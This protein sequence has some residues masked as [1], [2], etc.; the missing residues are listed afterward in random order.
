MKD[1]MIYN[2]KGK[3]AD[4]IRWKS[5]WSELIFDYSVQLLDKITKLFTI[6]SFCKNGVAC[7]NLFAL[8]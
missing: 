7:I 1:I 4:I 5:S 8:W 3:F 6:Q 2:K